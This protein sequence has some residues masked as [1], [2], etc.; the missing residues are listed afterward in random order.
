LI[1][2][3]ISLILQIFEEDVYRASTFIPYFWQGVS[4]RKYRIIIENM[5]LM[6]GLKDLV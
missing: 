6:R 4:E 5:E 3:S 2:E 1:H